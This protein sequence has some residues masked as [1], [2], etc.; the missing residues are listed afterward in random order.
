LSYAGGRVLNNCTLSPTP[1][2]RRKLVE[3]KRKA[4]RRGIW[5]TALSRAE[6]ACI[7]L[8]VQVVDRVRSLL[9]AK[10][11]NA[12]AKKLSEAMESKITRLVKEI[13]CKLALKISQIAQ[14]WGNTRATE[15]ALD[16]KFVRY[17]TIIKM[18]T[19]EAHKT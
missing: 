19:T 11:L 3:M 2:T 7:D 17:L 1:H 16:L 6:R 12:V 18:N 9:L 13:G 14:S 10:V 15:W 4:I 8:T 5:F